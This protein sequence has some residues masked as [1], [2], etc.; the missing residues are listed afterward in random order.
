MSNVIAA[1]ICGALFLLL[2]WAI[3]NAMEHDKRR[4]AEAEVL[5][6]G[7][8][9]DVRV[10]IDKKQGKQWRVIE[11]SVGVIILPGSERPWPDGVET[12]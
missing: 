8:P 6:G 12:P 10:L 1:L 11:H 9:Y 2:A 5:L 7:V 3:P 4:V